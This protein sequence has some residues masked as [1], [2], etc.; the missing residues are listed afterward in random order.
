M[1]GIS[2]EVLA[3]DAA[4]SLA[5]G[6]CKD[7]TA[8]WARWEDTYAAALTQAARL[9]ALTEPAAVCSACTVTAACADLADLSGYTG[10]AAGEGYR[11]G[12]ADGARARAPRERRSA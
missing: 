6:A 8:Q 4:W 11:N 9:A 2:R 12:R 1:R 5:D 7:L 10:I 3:R